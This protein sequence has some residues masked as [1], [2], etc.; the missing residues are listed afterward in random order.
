[1]SRSLTSHTIAS[2][3]KNNYAQRDTQQ[4]LHEL[5]VPGEVK[6]IV[7]IDKTVGRKPFVVRHVSLFI[8]NNLGI[9]SVS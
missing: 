1:M 5:T 9:I 4:K 8:G 2:A 6:Y 3:V 7:P